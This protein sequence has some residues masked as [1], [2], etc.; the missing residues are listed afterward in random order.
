MPIY[1]IIGNC[2][3][4]GEQHPILMKIH[5]A[6]GPTEPQTVAD[7]FHG[8]MLPPQV[9]AVKRHIAVCLK[10]GKKYSLAEDRHII[11]APA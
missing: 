4:C 6:A 1:E 9:L 5:L 11:L 8:Q 2:D 7:A 10:S 3:H